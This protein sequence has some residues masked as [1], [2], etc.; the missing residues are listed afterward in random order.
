MRETVKTVKIPTKTKISFSPNNEE[1]RKHLQVLES[2]INDKRRGDWQIV[3]PMVGISPMAAEKAFIRVYSK[4]H[5]EV[6]E[7]LRK[8]I[9]QRKELL[10]Q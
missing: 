1:E 4:N 5:F 3:G 9:D 8:V 2:L 6:V 10:K 7:A